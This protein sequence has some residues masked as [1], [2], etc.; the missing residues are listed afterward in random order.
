LSCEISNVSPF[1]FW[2]LV[3]EREYFLD[4]RAF[5][6]FKNAAVAD[7]MKVKALSEHHVRWPKLNIDL[8]LDSIKH[9]NNHP[10][11]AKSSPARNPV[12]TDAA[13]RKAR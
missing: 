11:T 5:P 9:P 10:L 1:G 4:H 6:W 7:V 8:D 13:R 2:L 12:S 3:G